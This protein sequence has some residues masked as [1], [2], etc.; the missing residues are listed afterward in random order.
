MEDN[1]LFRF[2]SRITPNRD[3]ENL[4]RLYWAE[5]VSFEQTYPDVPPPK[6]K[7]SLTL[8][9]AKWVSGEL[10]AE[11]MASLGADLLEAGY[12]TPTL[13]RLAGELNL[14]TRADAEPLVSQ[15]FKELG[16]LYPLQEDQAQIISIRQTSREVIHGQRNP[17][18]AAD[19]VEKTVC[20]WYTNNAL[21]QQLFYIHDELNW[22][23][24]D[25]R[26]IHEL[27]SDLLNTYAKL[28]KLEIPGIPS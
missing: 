22:D 16:V 20:S 26:A 24:S 14:R 18:S 9:A 7:N 23:T 25:R 19:Y 27:T 6:D 10:H 3:D 5:P 4:S 8:L 17:W 15:T 12:D 1:L 13:R 28:A 11:D 2:L 21:I